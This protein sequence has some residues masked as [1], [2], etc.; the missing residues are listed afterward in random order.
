MTWYVVSMCKSSLEWCDI[1]SILGRSR[2]ALARVV[3]A[4]IIPTPRVLPAPYII[5]HHIINDEPLSI[6][7]GLVRQRQGMLV[8]REA[9]RVEE[10][11]LWRDVTLRRVKGLRVA[12]VELDLVGPAR[13][14]SAPEELHCLTLVEG[15]NCWNALN[16]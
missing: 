12:A 13:G 5:C 2:P 14:T 1:R 4:G 9:V 16:G 11:R 8:V 3:R 7:H 6:R 10:E 15:E